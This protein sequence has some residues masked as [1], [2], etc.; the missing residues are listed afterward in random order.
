MPYLNLITIIKNYGCISN[1]YTYLSSIFIKM[2]DAVHRLVTVITSC[3]IYRIR[4]MVY[5]PFTIP[6]TMKMSNLSRGV[7]HILYINKYSAIISTYYTL[8]FSCWKIS[9]QPRRLDINYQL[10][11]DLIFELTS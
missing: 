3:S 4:V 7:T 8:T 9:L 1:P 5:Q 11:H 2:L 10:T 6:L